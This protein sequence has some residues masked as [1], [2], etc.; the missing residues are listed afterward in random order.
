MIA[1]S[2]IRK[3]LMMNSMKT[4]FRQCF[5][6]TG[7]ETTIFMFSIHTGIISVSTAK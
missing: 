4:K 7:I 2:L 1:I 6:K 5:R 3:S